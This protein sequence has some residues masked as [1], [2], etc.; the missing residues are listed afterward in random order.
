MKCSHITPGIQGMTGE[1]TGI[2]AV[3]G[4][5]DFNSTHTLMLNDEGEVFYIGNM[6]KIEDFISYNDFALSP[7]K[8]EGVPK[9]RK[10]GAGGNCY[11]DFAI[12]PQDNMVIWG[13]G[14][15]NYTGSQEPMLFM[16]NVEDA[17]ASTYNLYI[18]K[19]DGKLV[20]FGANYDGQRGD[21]TTYESQAYTGAVMNSTD[22]IHGSEIMGD[23]KKVTAGR[24]LYFD[25]ELGQSEGTVA[26]ALKTDG[27]LYGW[28]T[29]GL[30]EHNGQVL[31][32]CFNEPVKLAENVKDM[33][34]SYEDLYTIT[35]EGQLQKTSLASIG[36]GSIIWEKIICGNLPMEQ[37]RCGSFH[38]CAI[39]SLGMVF[40]VGENAEGQLGI[41]KE[42]LERSASGQATQPL[43]EMRAVSIGATR[44]SSYAVLPDGRLLA[45]GENDQ[46]QLGN[47]RMG[48]QLNSV[49]PAYVMSGIKNVYAGFKESYFITDNNDMY[50]AGSGLGIKGMTA[51]ATEKAVRPVKVM[52]DVKMVDTAD[53]GVVKNDN[54][55]WLTEDVG[56]YGYS[57]AMDDVIYYAASL[58]NSN[59][60]IIRGDN[61]LWGWG[62]NYSG[63]LGLGYYNDIE[64][65]EK[66][67]V[68]QPVKIMD[69]VRYVNATTD[70]SC[71]IIDLEGT[72]Y[73]CG[74]KYNA[75]SGELELNLVP[76]PI[77]Y[78]VEYV[79]GCR[80]GGVYYIDTMGRMSEW[81]FLGNNWRYSESPDGY[82]REDS[83]K[84]D[85]RNNV[86]KIQDS[87]LLDSDG[88][89]YIFIDSVIASLFGMDESEWEKKK[90]EY[91]EGQ[92]KCEL[93]IEDVKDIACS[94]GGDG[95]AYFAVKEN[96]EL[97]AWGNNQNGQLG[98]G[99]AG[100]DENIFEVK[101]PQ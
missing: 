24:G 80:S 26:F 93:M 63:E 10:I 27:T 16:E 46:G 1:I 73:H 59:R 25:K 53:G 15:E 47:G 98:L 78:D 50:V 12:T 3:S 99:D 89:C 82:A 45:W 96:G 61:S 90:K 92:P 30:V 6:A 43:G 41:P 8:I 68:T 9:A 20:V 44:T 74:E 100:S 85:V 29:F 32:M 22:F 97:Y 66:T 95:A 49:E 40:T 60:W 88:K 33:D 52:E 54:T 69:D 64:K 38:A 2:V 81:N 11:V 39:D 86:R 23:V 35:R 87:I 57:K 14:A 21:G 67:P 7:Q 101:L 70:G 72:L 56:F 19:T 55:L 31:K 4:G 13:L 91:G 28:G 36:K 5:H 79:F 62:D 83:S 42:K 75:E 48:Q 94:W 34:C 58:G 18:L 76:E 51:G 84:R 65:T 77:A 37:V 71:Y 17:F